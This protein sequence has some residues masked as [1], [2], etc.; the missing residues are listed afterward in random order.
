MSLGCEGTVITTYTR[1][2]LL[3]DVHG[4]LPALMAV[5]ADVAASDVDAVVNLGCLT[6]GPQ[7][8][9]V[10]R[11][12]LGC[13]LPV[14][15]VRGN[16]ERAVLEMTYDGRECTH[17][18][19]F[20]V[21]AH[22]PE[23]LEFVAGTRPLVRFEIEGL[24]QV[25]A[26]HG[27]P[28][29]DVELVTP[30][31]PEPRLRAAMAGLEDCAVVASGHT[32]LQFVRPLPGLLSVNP[33]SVGLPYHDGPPGARW[34]VM[35]AGGAH[36]RVTAYDLDAAVRAVEDLGYPAA[37]RWRESLLRPPRFA[38]IVADAESREFSD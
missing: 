34:M 21:S 23:A 4:N 20:V 11:Q 32:H 38:E 7:P 17:R 29:S 35:D 3:S 19:T 33:G 30:E 27:S 1:I 37:D 15:S 31:T 8:S 6:F 14:H 12:L 18:D 2:A 22:D 10:V 25:V 9:E 36:A 5:L 26:C 16:G 24:G 28:R 13:G